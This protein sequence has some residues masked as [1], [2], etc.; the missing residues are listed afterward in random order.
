[1]EALSSAADMEHVGLAEAL[2]LVLHRHRK[3]R[4]ADDL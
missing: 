2:E 3:K 1:M 4:L